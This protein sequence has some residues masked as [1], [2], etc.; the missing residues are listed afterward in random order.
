VHFF[1]V[2]VV[3][4]LL[5][6]IFSSASAAGA[7]REGDTGE[8][9]VAIQSRL[10][11]LGY[12]PGGSDGDFG[13][14]TT[15]AVKRFQQDRGMEAD[16]LV[17]AETYRALLGR[18]IPVSRDGSSATLRR[19]IQ[20][21]SRYL[22]VPYVFGGTTPDGFDCSGFTRYVYG[23]SGI[24]LPRTADAQYGVGHPVS[25]NRLQAG[26][27]VFFS[28]YEEGISH[29][30]IY[31]GNGQFISA[32]SSQGVAVASLNSGYWGAR[33]MGARRVL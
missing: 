6:G 29:S 26:D 25:I 24:F 14:L 21:A 15:E 7:Y 4:V 19:V 20:T 2:L 16:G 9:V 5:F 12:N 18:E 10:A 31:L 33:Y 32:T 27:L 13:S 1:R 11:S 23:Q 28:T 17:G 22:G 3:F 8:D 30:G